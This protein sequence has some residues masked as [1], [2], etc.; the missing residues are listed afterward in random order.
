MIVMMKILMVMI[1][2]ITAIITMTTYD[3]KFLSSRSFPGIMGEG[4]HAV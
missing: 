2:I 3:E 4:W 1:M